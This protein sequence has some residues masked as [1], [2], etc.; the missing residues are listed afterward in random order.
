MWRKPGSVLGGWNLTTGR[1][2]SLISG[3]SLRR[4]EKADKTFHSRLTLVAI[5]II[6][7]LPWQFIWLLLKNTCWGRS[8]LSTP[9]PLCWCNPTNICFLDCNSSLLGG[10]SASLWPPFS[11]WHSLSSNTSKLYVESSHSLSQSPLWCLSSPPP[12]SRRQNSS[13]NPELWHHYEH[14]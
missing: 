6:A 13:N 10:L 11:F 2:L 14:N 5:A 12:A 8:L 1:A 3:T 7:V 9:A 4:K